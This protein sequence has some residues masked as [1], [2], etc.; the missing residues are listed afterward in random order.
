LPALLLVSSTP[1]THAFAVF[2]VLT[3]LTVRLVTAWPFIRTE[4]APADALIVAETSK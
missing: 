3:P 4:T 2:C 1:L